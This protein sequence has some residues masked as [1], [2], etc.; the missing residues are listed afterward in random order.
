MD[1][2]L[3]LLQRNLN[4]RELGH[5]CTNWGNFH[6]GLSTINLTWSCSEYF[7]TF[8]AWFLPCLKAE[9]PLL[10]FHL[11]ELLQEHHGTRNTLHSAR[12]ISGKVALFGWVFGLIWEDETSKHSLKKTAEKS[13]TAG[14]IEDLDG[15]PTPTESENHSVASFLCLK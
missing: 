1:T 12:T 11:K 6:C 14:K 13:R 2:E 15:F 10:A 4:T 8:S 9:L 3:P 5:V 7:I